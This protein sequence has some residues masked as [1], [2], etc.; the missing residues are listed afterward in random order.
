M[1]FAIWPDG[2]WIDLEDSSIEEYSWMSDDY[3][4]TDVSPETD[5]E[6]LRAWLAES[7]AKAK[8]LT[9]RAQYYLDNADTLKKVMSYTGLKP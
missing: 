7:Q 6:Q 8:F 1:S 3:I 2:T 5:E 9:K 4:T